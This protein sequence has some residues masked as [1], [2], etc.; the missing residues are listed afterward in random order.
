MHASVIPAKLALAS[1][2][3]NPGLVSR[4]RGKDGEGTFRT[5]EVRILR[6]ALDVSPGKFTLG[7]SPA[8]VKRQLENILHKLR[9][10]GLNIV[11]KD[12][13]QK[14]DEELLK[15]IADGAGK[16]PASKKLSKAEQKQTLDYS[17][18]LAK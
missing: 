15:I 12:T 2:S 9:A 14:S 18:S 13:T 17:R 6:K 1:A 7:I 3:R 4:F 11:S 16:M 8:T 5:N 10:R